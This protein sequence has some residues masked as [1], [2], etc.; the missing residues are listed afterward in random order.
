LLD[1]EENS[2]GK[3]QTTNVQDSSVE[4][5]GRNQA[6]ILLLVASALYASELSFVAK[7][8]ESVPVGIS[9]V[10]RFGL[11][12]LSVLPLLFNGNGNSGRRHLTR[13]G[14]FCWKTEKVGLDIVSHD[15]MRVN[16]VMATSEKD[17][18]D[19]TS[20]NKP[21]TTS[22]QVPLI[23]SRDAE[24]V[25]HVPSSS[26]IPRANPE[27]S[28][29]VD[30]RCLAPSTPLKE[31][32][33]KKLFFTGLEIGFYNG[34]GLTMNSLLLSGKIATASE[35][36][37]FGSLSTVFVPLLEYT[38]IPF[39]DSVF[40]NCIAKSS[41]KKGG[42]GTAI[43]KRMKWSQKCGIVMAIVGLGMLEGPFGHGVPISV[44]HLEA[45]VVQRQSVWERLGVNLAGSVALK[46][47]IHSIENHSV[48]PVSIME[49]DSSETEGKRIELIDESAPEAEP[50][51]I[52]PTK[53]ESHKPPT[54]R[55][56]NNQR[57]NDD[58]SFLSKSGD[59]GG[60]IS[61]VDSPEYSE[62]VEKTS[63]GDAKSIK[64]ES[65]VVELNGHWNNN[66]DEFSPDTSGD[67]NDNDAQPPLV[68][69]LD[70]S[71]N[72]SVTMREDDANPLSLK[73]SSDPLYPRHSLDDP[74][75]RNSKWRW[76]KFKKLICIAPPIC[77]ALGF[78]KIEQAMEKY[79]T[80]AKPITAAHIIGIFVITII[81]YFLTATG[82]DI[83][84]VDATS[85][86][87][88]MTEITLSHIAS[89][90]ATPVILFQLLWSGIAS[91][92]IGIY[93]ESLAMKTLSASESVVIFS[94][95]PIF[96]SAFASWFCGEIFLG[97]TIIGVLGAF[98]IV[99]G[100]IIS[101]LGCDFIGNGM[102]RM[103]LIWACRHDNVGNL[104]RKK[105]D[106][107][108]I[109]NIGENQGMNQ[110]LLLPWNEEVSSGIEVIP[111][112]VVNVAPIELH[113]PPF[114]GARPT[115]LR[116]ALKDTFLAPLDDSETGKQ[117]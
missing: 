7:L 104:S 33:L 113:T 62:H 82:V 26:N 19:A 40:G 20:C 105:S 16:T 64:V 98:C 48:M 44:A 14:R 45:V 49:Q 50:P 117:A 57:Y 80:A 74:E 46:P 107:V 6:R 76:I 65:E 55:S 10:L 43:T 54:S 17:D 15:G 108:C 11:A 1:Q 102:K 51:P 92:V 35:L 2:P 34:I 115:R 13:R 4:D 27:P 110:I 5:K 111:C 30:G 112:S 79:P 88:V 100:C 18:D 29:D 77:F 21:E 97:G 73:K 83:S 63:S 56:Y 60:A 32:P 22:L 72:Q 101:E 8:N 47:S 25:L 87:D 58:G 36:A 114:L 81:C 94:T 84:P 68:D 41:S 61:S 85:S 66:D 3:T 70:I 96:A 90:L 23:E 37:F 75:E 91:I 109:E 103:Q 59:I 42:D 106:F 31:T 39:F 89:W 67:L 95:E 86:I 93:L 99:A 52:D 69:D 53:Y 12:S 78:Y 28:N 116:R 9:L 71:E 24:N 38:F